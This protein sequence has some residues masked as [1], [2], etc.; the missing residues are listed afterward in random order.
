MSAK[1]SHHKS[2]I[3]NLAA[4]VEEYKSQVFTLF[5][6]QQEESEADKLN[7]GMTLMITGEL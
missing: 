3:A 6:K 1:S 2:Q 5:T 4:K 7:K